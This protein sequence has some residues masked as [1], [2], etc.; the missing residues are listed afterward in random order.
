MN[1]FLYKLTK[2]VF[3]FFLINIIYLLVLIFTDW[4]IK[5]RIESISFENPNYE[6]LVLGN[7]LAMDGIDTDF[8]SKNGI[9]S[10]N[11]SL[12]GSSVKTNYIIL[13]EYLERYRNKPKRLILALGSYISSFENEEINPIVETTN[14]EYT[15]KIQDIPIV[16]FKWLGEELI[17]KIIS[18]NHR[19]AIISK[20]QLKF[21]KKVADNTKFKQNTLNMKMYIKSKY[22]REIVKI[23]IDNDIELMIF[24][25]PGYR[26]TRNDDLIG[27]YYLDYSLS[28]KIPLYNFN[29]KSFCNLFDSNN[30]WIGNSH[31]NE[32]G[33]FKF[34]KEMYNMNFKLK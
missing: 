1:N 9:K 22:I 13:K 7:S 6:L 21:R 24:E 25:M 33:A 23:C 2:F 12:G 26:E 31:L 8:L 17:K 5:K 10:Y 20:G 4:N 34:T 14:T 28:K 3:G 15:F 27:P 30:D 16:K 18:N 32:F 19:N 29:S 11:L